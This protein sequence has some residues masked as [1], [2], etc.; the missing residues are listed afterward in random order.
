MFQLKKMKR[1]CYCITAAAFL[2][3]I[4]I[5][6]ISARDTI[7]TTEQ[8]AKTLNIG[9]F[10]AGHVQGIAVDKSNGFIYYS[11]TTM[12][13]KTDMNGRIIGSVKG[14]L[15]HLGCLDFNPMNGRL[16]GSLEYKNDAIGKG[17][18]KQENKSD[19]KINDAFYIAVFDVNRIDRL[20]MDAEKDGVMKVVYLPEVAADYSAE[21]NVNG[22]IYKHRLACSGIDGL[23]FGPKFG[24]LNDK[25]YLTVAY[26]IYGD[27]ERSDNDYQ[28]ILQY[29]IQ[30]WNKYEHPLSQG[31]VRRKGPEKPDGKYY[32]YTGNTSFGVQN[33][34]FDEF[35]NLWFMAVYNGR[36]SSFP[37][38]SIY[39]VDA[40][41]KPETKTLKGVPYIKK[42]KVI[43][44]AE[45]GIKDSITGI[46]GWKQKLG[47]TGMESLGDGLFYF[48]KNYKENR[49]QYCQL[50]LY[51]LDTRQ[52]NPF[53]EEK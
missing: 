46:R 36:K 5:N 32:I 42:G 50:K 23:G 52:E 19:L 37:N 3:S 40:S 44:L 6:P 26:G 25:R 39:A 33:L 17:I 1:F 29:D 13:I 35:S 53:M 51:R 48:S 20:D 34:E 10:K 11:F 12:L 45:I 18:L 41:A 4:H 31:N 43:S 16:Y 27:T 28:V 7:P 9:P 15:G 24:E 47:A 22:K 8:Y 14:L 21:V 38:Y 49:M 2:L 30:N